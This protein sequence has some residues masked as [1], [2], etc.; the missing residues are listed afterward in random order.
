MLIRRRLTTN[1]ASVSVTSPTCYLSA[2]VRR[3]IFKDESQVFDIVRL[4][5]DV[6]LHLAGGRGGGRERERER[7][8]SDF[9]KISKDK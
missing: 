7:P 1:T 2:N 4:K 9:L 3:G 5:E 6:D 8:T